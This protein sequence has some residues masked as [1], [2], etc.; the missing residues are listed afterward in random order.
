MRASVAATYQ[1]A[2]QVEASMVSES[3]RLLRVISSTLSE[4]F[5]NEANGVSLADTLDQLLS[6]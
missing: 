6:C 5:Y 2:W 1:K 3:V 4:I